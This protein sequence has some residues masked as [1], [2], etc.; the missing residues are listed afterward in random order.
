MA[1]WLQNPKFNEAL[2]Q[3]KLGNPRDSKYM[4][5]PK[6]KCLSGVPVLSCRDFC[7]PDTNVKPNNIHA[8]AFLCLSDHV[9]TL[10]STPL[11]SVCSVLLTTKS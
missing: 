5:Q 2:G 9:S 1:V 7:L 11:L 8:Y 10:V 4:V 3:R 6:S